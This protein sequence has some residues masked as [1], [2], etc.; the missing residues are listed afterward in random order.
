VYRE[1]TYGCWHMYAYWDAHRVE[2]A[3]R[4]VVNGVGKKVREV[5]AGCSRPLEGPAKRGVG[6]AG[7]FR[8]RGRGTA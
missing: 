2:W 6:L 5:A 4:E 8:S 7:S 3:R 1:P